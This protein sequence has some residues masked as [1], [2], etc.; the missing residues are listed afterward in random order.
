MKRAVGAARRYAAGSMAAVPAVLAGASWHALAAITAAV[1]AVV[2]AVC[3]AIA[4]P[5]RARRLS[6]LIRAW[7]GPG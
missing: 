3:W 1:L 2:V 7:R 4:D 5:G 6:A